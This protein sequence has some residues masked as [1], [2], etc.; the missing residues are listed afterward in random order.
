M[1]AIFPINP[2][3]PNPPE[4]LRLVD[5]HGNDHNGLGSARYRTVI[6]PFAGRIFAFSFAPDKGLVD[7]DRA[8]QSLAT[9]SRH[10]TTKS[11]EHSPSCLVAS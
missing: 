1:L 2:A 10:G 3:E 8:G 11:V 6:T 7:L 5:F 9:C 4:A